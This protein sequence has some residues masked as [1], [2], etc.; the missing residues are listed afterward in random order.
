MEEQKTALEDV[1]LSITETA[2]TKV[3]EMAEKSSKQGYGLRIMVV[4]GGCSGFQY[5]M[6]FE[7][8]AKEDDVVTEVSG[9]KFFVDKWSLK[10]LS[11][12][13]VDY[14]ESFQGAGFKIDN[15][16]ARHSC[17]CGNSFG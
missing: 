8:S 3:R 10:M 14:V 15:P 12:A 11:G 2:A 9:V 16:N 6:D 4:P 13:K 17:G 5:E 1:S 7:N